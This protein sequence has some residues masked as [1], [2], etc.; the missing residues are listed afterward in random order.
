M[1]EGLCIAFAHLVGQWRLVGL[2]LQAALALNLVCWCACVGHRAKC[3]SL[4]ALV[5]RQLMEPES[6]TYTYIV[7]DPESHQAVI[8]DPVDLTVRIED[9]CMC[10]ICIHKKSRRLLTF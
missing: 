7:A 2:V 4:P 9:L 1:C 10:P 6:C 3:A 8:I 5:V